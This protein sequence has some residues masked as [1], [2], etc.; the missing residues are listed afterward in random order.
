MS[1]SSSMYQILKCDKQGE[2]LLSIEIISPE[3]YIFDYLKTSAVAQE[4]VIGN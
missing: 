3:S 4:I 2:T 1:Q